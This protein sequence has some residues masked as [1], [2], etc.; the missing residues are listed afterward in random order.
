MSFAAWNSNW[1]PSFPSLPTSP[2]IL[3]RRQFRPKHLCLCT[4]MQRHASQPKKLFQMFQEICLILNPS[5]YP[6]DH[7]FSASLIQPELHHFASTLPDCIMLH[8][9]KGEGSYWEE[10][11][12]R[13]S[14]FKKPN[15]TPNQPKCIIASLTAANHFWCVWCVWQTRHRPGTDL[16]QLFF[17]L[18]S[19]LTK[20][21]PTGGAKSTEAAQIQRLSNWHKNHPY[22]SVNVGIIIPIIWPIETVFGFH[23][24]NLGV[25][26]PTSPKR[27]SIWTFL[28]KPA[29]GLDPFPALSLSLSLSFPLLL[30]A[31]LFLGQVF[32]LD[33]GG[34]SMAFPG[35]RGVHPSGTPISPLERQA[36]APGII[37][38]RFISNQ[39]SNQDP[40]RSS[41]FS[42]IKMSLKKGVCHHASCKVKKKSK[43]HQDP[44]LFS[45]F[46]QKP[47]SEEPRLPPG[48]HS[49]SWNL[50]WTSYCQRR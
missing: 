26:I 11:P 43:I 40:S 22:N 25:I 39:P 8:L 17:H 9:K 37:W 35:N 23:P 42:P 18:A 16:S 3:L 44:P 2:Q 27:K 7:R 29:T 4:Q 30:V 47:P 31:T 50:G 24:N 36:A 10:V 1:S 19:L 14:N 20:F 45:G 48:T 6:R 33:L 32:C 34:I 38:H 28:Q 12:S 49:G 41:D 15:W 5:I 46:T 21:L 13:P